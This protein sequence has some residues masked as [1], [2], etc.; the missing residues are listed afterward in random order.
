MR[1]VRMYTRIY[2]TCQ[3]YG[4]N[5]L[6]TTEYFIASDNMAYGAFLLHYHITSHTYM[7]HV[8]TIS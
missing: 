7:L 5:F 2:E 3:Y 6:P 8:Y 4:N 1:A